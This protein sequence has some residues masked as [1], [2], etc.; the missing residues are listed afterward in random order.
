MTQA[1]NLSQLANFVNSSGQ[2]DASTGLYNTGSIGFATG[3][4]M[5]FQ[6][7]S[8]PTGWTKDTTA[9]IND[10]MIRLVTGTASSGGSTAFSTWSAGTTV[11]SYTLATTD[12]PQHTHNYT[13]RGGTTS[14]GKYSS[15]WWTGTSTAATDGGTGGGGSHNHSVTRSLKYYD[16]I[17]ASK[18]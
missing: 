3:T 8:A 15:G 6:Q 9:A 5:A 11:G 1:F 18:N 4:R 2:L 10:S 13:Y 17:I 14:G 7:T 12:I 16:F